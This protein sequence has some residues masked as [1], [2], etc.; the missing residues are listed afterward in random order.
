MFRFLDLETSF[1][2][3]ED[4]EQLLSLTQIE[5]LSFLNIELQDSDQLKT[6]KNKLSNL[7]NYMV[8]KK[9]SYFFYFHS[10]F[11]MGDNNENSNVWL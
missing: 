11:I 4:K 10:Y 3:Q 5:E 7:K 1:V 9:A 8:H 2:K 6:L